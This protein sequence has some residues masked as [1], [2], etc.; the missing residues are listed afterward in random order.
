MKQL[1]CGSDIRFMA[2][3]STIATWQGLHR[4]DA[5]L[6]KFDPTKFEPVIVDECH[7]AASP[8]GV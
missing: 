5:R 2:D 4:T 3:D 1:I 6:R 8:K 7:R